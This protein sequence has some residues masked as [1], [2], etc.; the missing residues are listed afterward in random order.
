MLCLNLYCGTRG[1]GRIVQIVSETVSFKCYQVPLFYSPSPD[2][3]VEEDT[4]RSVFIQRFTAP[5]LCAKNGNNILKFR[6]HCCSI[7][8]PSYEVMTFAVFA[9]FFFTPVCE[10]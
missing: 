8:T 9:Q 5:V 7:L 2:L 1:F 6:Q 10:I 3:H 4:A